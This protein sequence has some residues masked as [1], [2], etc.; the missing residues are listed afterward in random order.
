MPSASFPKTLKSYDREVG[1][2]L[3][4]CNEFEIAAHGLASLDDA[5]ADYVNFKFTLSTSRGPRER[6]VNAVMG[7][8]LFLPRFS[9]KMLKA[10]AIYTSWDRRRPAKSPPPLLFGIVV[11]LALIFLAS[12][13]PE[14]GLS[15][16][17][18]FHCYLRVRVIA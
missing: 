2:F 6:Y 5:L 12:G 16:L 17:L 7:V 18:G 13:A 3:F 14:V 11:L 15:C 9:K 8:E 1:D 4:Y 10:R